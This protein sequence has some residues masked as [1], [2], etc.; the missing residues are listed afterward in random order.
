[1]G[2]AVVVRAS[3]ELT[4]KGPD[5]GRVLKKHGIKSIKP[6]FSPTADTHLSSERSMDLL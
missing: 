3:A 2:R 1:M 5:M 6:I 4:T